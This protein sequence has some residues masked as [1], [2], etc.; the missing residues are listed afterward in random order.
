MP[1]RVNVDF[2]DKAYEA[3]KSLADRKD[4]TMS[5]VLRDAIALEQWFEDTKGD[6][7]KVLV[8]NKGK[9]QEIVRP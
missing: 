5:E 3:L 2:S 8:E 4:K 9:V 7:A 1:K 6:G